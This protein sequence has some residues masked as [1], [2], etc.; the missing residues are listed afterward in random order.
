MLEQIARDQPQARVLRQG[1]TIGRLSL[2]MVTTNTAI[3][4][5]ARLFTTRAASHVLL[6]QDT[7]IVLPVRFAA[8]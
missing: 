6:S 3:V 2:T 1:R 8:L 5:A 4:L 7:M